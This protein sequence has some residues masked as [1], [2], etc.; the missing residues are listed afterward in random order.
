VLSD[1]AALRREGAVEV[2]EA[3]LRLRVH[4]PLLWGPAARRLLRSGTPGQNRRTSGAD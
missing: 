2:L 1:L 4:N 3:V